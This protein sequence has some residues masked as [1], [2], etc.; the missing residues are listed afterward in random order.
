MLFLARLFLLPALLQGA[1]ASDARSLDAALDAIAPAIKK[2]AA[3]CVVTRDADGKPVFT[4]HDYRGTAGATDFWP[5]STIKLYT[6]VAALELLNARGFT[7][8]STTAIFE[9]QVDGR[10]IT[11]CARGMPEMLSEVFRR[12]SN[13]DY[14]L[15]LRMAGIDAINT[16]FLIPEKG[17]PHSALMR[18]YV[19]TRPHVY[20]TIE[21]QRITLRDGSGRTDTFEH[22]WSG[23]S[24][25]QDRGVAV[26]N[27][28]T[29]NLT[30]PRELG[31]CLRRVMFHEDLPPAERYRLT[32]SQLQF[33]RYGA[34]GFCGLE[35]KGKDS[36]P[37]AWESGVET[38]FPKARF[39]HKCGTISSYALEVACVD[40]SAESGKR[41]ILVPVVQAGSDTKPVRGEKL[42]GQMAKAIAEWVKGN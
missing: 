12:S 34:D 21:P 8:E 37:I 41:F 9:R 18:G 42:V 29:G 11:D 25:A 5:A 28:Q 32:P 14:T 3:V 17:F 23:R 1:R 38:V 2:W 16:Q 26:F 7:F 33:L 13:E 40:D 27:V 10:W 20:R 30:S 15:L 6:A 39:F 19:T 31:E 35:T 36:G 24:Y 22:V 4:W